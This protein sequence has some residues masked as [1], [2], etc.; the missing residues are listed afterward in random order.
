MT[1]ALSIAASNDAFTQIWV[2]KG[3]YTSIVNIADENAYNTG[4]EE[5]KNKAFLLPAGI[6]I[7]GGFPDTGTPAI[8]D[9]KPY[10]NTTILSGAS[11]YHTIVAIDIAEKTVL[12]GFTISGG[13]ANYDAN[14]ILVKGQTVPK[15]S[16]AGIYAYNAILDL[17]NILL[18]DNSATNNGGALYLGGSTTEVNLVNAFVTKN[19]ATANGGFAYVDTGATLNIYSATITGNTA[20]DG[21]DTGNAIYNNN[22]TVT[23]NSTIIWGNKYADSDVFGTVTSQYSLIK[24]INSGENGN[25]A[26]T[27]NPL[28]KVDN[29]LSL[30][31]S[32]IDGGN[33]N[34]LLP[35]GITKD[36]AGNE[37]IIGDNIDMGA[38][39][40]T[41][42]ET[43][44]AFSHLFV[45]AAVTGGSEDGSSWSNAM[46]SLA[47]ALDFANANYGCITEIWVAQGTYAPETNP[48]SL[49]PDQN[50]AFLL[51]AGVRIYGG[52]ADNLADGE[53]D[54]NDRPF[55][56]QTIL[57][58]DLSS[59]TAYHVLIGVDIPYYETETSTVINTL[60]DGFVITGGYASASSN[61]TVSGYAIN[62]AHGGA[63]CLFNASPVLNNIIVENNK[64]RQH[65]GAFYIDRNS[66]P[67]INNTIFRGNAAS[68]VSAGYGGAMYIFGASEVSMYNVLMHGNTSIQGNNGYGGAICVSEANSV[69]N[70]TNT[71]ITNNRAGSTNLTTSG[72]GI[73]SSGKL[74]VKNSII[75]GNYAGT[76]L[77]T[78][79][80]NNFTNVDAQYS[81]IKGYTSV[82]NGNLPNTMS[83]DFV[84]VSADNYRLSPTSPAIDAGNNS[85]I[86]AGSSTDITG[87]VSRVLNGNV[88]MGAYE[89]DG[90]RE[91][92][93]VLYVNIKAN[94]GGTGASWADPI[95]E[96]S[97]ALE[98]VKPGGEIWVA[99]GT[100]YPQG[101]GYVT[102]NIPDYD[103][104]FAL[105]MGV[106]IY[107]GFPENPTDGIDKIDRTDPDNIIDTRD[108]E[109]N[110]TILSGD[111]DESGSGSTADASHVV[112]GIGLPYNEGNPALNTIL[113]GLVI[114]GGYAASTGSL[115]MQGVNVYRYNGGGMYL[116]NASPVLNNIVF[117]NN[118]A[119]NTS[120]YGGALMLENASSP[121]INN[122][123]FDG[124]IAYNGGGAIYSSGNNA[125]LI[126]N[127]IFKNNRVN[128]SSSTTTTG[129]G[130]GA[131]NI[132]NSG[133]SEITLIN[134]LLH[135]NASTCSGGAIYIYTSSANGS[136]VNLINSTISDNISSSTSPYGGAIYS[137]WGTVNLQNSIVFGNGSVSPDIQGYNGTYN[138]SYS[139][140]RGI[141]DEENGNISGNINPKLTSGYAL[142]ACSPLID[143]GSN[144]LFTNSTNLTTD[145]AG[146]T[147]IWNATDTDDQENATIDIGAY[148]R[149]GSNMSPSKVYVN[150]NTTKLAGT[151]ESWDSPLASLADALDAAECG[152]KEIWVAEGNYYSL[153]EN[154]FILPAGVKIYG[155]FPNPEVAG[156]P[157][158]LDISM[159][160]F[161][162]YP[163]VLDGGESGDIS[164]NSLHTIVGVNITA[165]NETVLD[166]FI[167]RDSQA[168]AYP[169]GTSTIKGVEV[170]KE[171]GGGIYL[172]N[173]SVMLKNII[174]ENCYASLYGGGIY[175][176]GNSN[177]QLVNSLIHGN[178]LGST[179][180]SRGAGIYVDGENTL[181]LVNTTIA[182]NKTSDYTP[183]DYYFLGSGI[184][185]DNG[186]IIIENSIVWGN[187][188]AEGALVHADNSPA[189]NVTR[190]Y[191]MV[192]GIIVPENDPDK[193]IS[194]INPRFVGSYNYRLQP[195]SP[196]LDKGSND[197][198]SA[199]PETD[200]NEDKDLAGNLRFQGTAID[201][202]AFEGGSCG[203]PDID[204][205]ANRRIL[206]HAEG[207]GYGTSWG[208]AYPSLAAAMKKARELNQI[209]E[210]AIT[211]IWV[212]AGTYYP[213]E[214]P[215]GVDTSDDRNKAFVLMEGVSIYGG[216][217]PDLQGSEGDKEDRPFKT[218][219]ILSGDIGYGGDENKIQFK[220]D[221]AAP[222]NDDG[223]YA[224]T[225]DN[226]Y[227]VV[228]S[229]AQ[230]RY[231]IFDG[232]VIEGGTANSLSVSTTGMEAYHG[233]GMYIDN[234]YS[235]LKD[236][237]MRN[238]TANTG[239]GKGGGLYIKGSKELNF[240][241][242]AFINNRA[243]EGGGVYAQGEV[244]VYISNNYGETISSFESN[245]ATIRGGAICSEDNMI[246]ISGN[247]GEN[248]APYGGAI[249]LRNAVINLNEG[250]FISNEA[251]LGGAIYIKELSSY[252]YSYLTA[253][254][255][256]N[257]ATIHGGA[258]YN[259]SGTNQTGFSIFGSSVRFTNNKA[260][261]GNGG[262]VYSTGAL[263]FS[264][265]EY[266]SFVGN[267]ALNGSGGALYLIDN[268][269]LGAT[270]D[271]GVVSGNKAKHSGAGIYAESIDYRISPGFS[272]RDN[273]LENGEGVGAGIFNIASTYNI[274]GNRS[275]TYGKPNFSNII[276]NRSLGEG[277]GIA[278]YLG[279]SGEISWVNISK[280]I[281]GSY[282]AAISNSYSG[283][284]S[285]ENVKI[286][287]NIATGDAVLGRGGAAV[288]N[289]NSEMM[290]IS[291]LVS[292]NQITAHSGAAIFNLSSSPTL[293][294][295]TIVN[296]TAEL[297]GNNDGAA[298]YN[299]GT[300][301]AGSNPL[302]YN[303]IIWGNT[304]SDEYPNVYNDG[305]SNP[306][307]EYSLI[308]GAMPS[309]V[310]NTTFGTDGG[311]NLD[312]DPGFIE[313][314][315]YF[316]L[317]DGGPASGT[318]SINLF[319]NIAPMAA[320]YSSDLFNLQRSTLIDEDT[321]EFAMSRG[322]YEAIECP[323]FINPTAGIV[324]VSEAGSGFM[325][326]SSWTDAYPGLADPL[327]Y[328]A[329]NHGCILEIWVAKGTY[330][331]GYKIAE[332]V[333][334]IN[335]SIPTTSRDK[336]FALVENVKIYGG[337]E[338]VESEKSPQDRDIDKIHT[339][340]QTILSGD[341]DYAESNGNQSFKDDYSVLNADNT[342]KGTEGNAY[343]VVIALGVTKTA[344]LDGFTIEGG[345][346]DYSE[347]KCMQGGY[348]C[349][350]YDTD[351]DYAGIIDVADNN[352]SQY[353]VLRSQG[354]GLYVGQNAIPSLHNLK[355]E[356][357][358]A[359]MYGGGVY[360]EGGIE[361]GLPTRIAKFA[362]P[363]DEIIIGDRS[364]YAILSMDSVWIMNNKAAFGAGVYS[365]QKGLYIKHFDFHNNQTFLID[366]QKDNPVG[367]VGGGIYALQ[368][369][370]DLLN[371][372]IT[373][374][375][376]GRAGGIFIAYGEPTTVT[377]ISP[378]YSDNPGSN[379]E[380]PGYSLTNVTLSS[381]HAVN[382]MT[383][384]ADTDWKNVGGL[385]VD[386]KA[387]HPC[388]PGETGLGVINNSIIWG[389]TQGADFDISN[390]AIGLSRNSATDADEISAIFRNSLMQESNG[391][392]NDWDE[393]RFGTDGLGNIDEDPRFVDYAGRNYRLL[394]TSPA[395]DTGLNKLYT[396][397]GGLITDKDIFDN[398]RFW[399][400]ATDSPIDAVIDMGAFEY[401]EKKSD[402]PLDPDV[403]EPDLYAGKIFVNSLRDGLGESWDCAFHSMY[404]ALIRA[405]QIVAAG[406]AVP[407][408][409][410]AK[411]YYYPEKSR[412][413]DGITY[414]DER[415]KSF[416]L[417]DGVKIYGGYADDLF[418]T[419]TSS[420]RD[421]MAETILSG[422]IDRAENQDNANGGILIGREGNAYHTV[423]SPLVNGALL[424]GFTITGGNAN[425]LGS[426]EYVA[427]IP[428]MNYHG[429]G[430]S[431]TNDVNKSITLTNVTF[432][433]NEADKAVGLGG[434]AYIENNIVFGENV[435]FE[436]NN[437][438][439]GGGLY[440]VNLENIDGTIFTSN[441]ATY[442]G[443]IYA[444]G[445]IFLEDKEDA[446]PTDFSK[447]RASLYG[448]AIYI[449]SKVNTSNLSNF[450]V[451]ENQAA[452]GGGAYVS[453][454]SLLVVDSKFTNN[455]ATVYGGGGLYN[456]GL[457]PASEADFDTNIIEIYS[458]AFSKNK[459]LSGNG[460]AIYTQFGNIA[461]DGLNVENNEALQGS[462]GGIYNLIGEVTYSYYQDQIIT[463]EG[464]KARYEGGGIAIMD[465]PTNTSPIYGSRASFG[466]IRGSIANNSVTNGLGGGIF[467]YNADMVIEPEPENRVTILS[468]SAS[469]EGGGIANYASTTVNVA[470]TNILNNETN[471]Y[472]GG[473]SNSYLDNLSNPDNRSIFKNVEISN[474]LARNI[475]LDE[476]TEN[477][478]GGAGMYNYASSPKLINVLLGRNVLGTNNGAGI[479]NMDESNTTLVNVTIAGN[480]APN[481]EGTGVYINNSNPDIYNTVVAKNSGDGQDFYTNNINGTIDVQHSLLVGLGIQGVG[482]DADGNW[483]D[484]TEPYFRNTVT[485]DFRLDEQEPEQ[486]LINTGNN[487]LYDQYSPQAAAS[488]F[489]LDNKARLD[490]TTIDIGAYE[491]PSPIKIPVTIKVM[492]QGP[493][494]RAVD[495]KMPDN[496]QVG[497]AGFGTVLSIPV[498]NPYGIYGVS[499]PDIHDASKVGNIAD[500][501]HVTIRDVVDPRVI[502]EERA[503]LLRVDGEIVEIDGSVPEF[504]PQDNPVFITVSHRNHMDILSN[505]VVL[506]EN[507]AGSVYDF[508]TDITQ[509]HKHPDFNDLPPMV[510][511]ESIPGVWCMWVGDI[512][513]DGYVDSED[514]GL[515]ITDFRIGVQAEYVDTDVN[516]DGYV[517]S[518]DTGYVRTN[519]RQGPISPLV[520]YRQQLG[521][522]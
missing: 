408:I 513:N 102:V 89:F 313:N 493:M 38:F 23:A 170:N 1:N 463:I 164:F 253:Q 81:L 335:G 17:K 245:E 73:H 228:V 160:D 348:N 74:N 514:V 418:G 26:G 350:W 430:I 8:G 204:V 379:N 137:Y 282:G 471:G 64:S 436:T 422:D 65:G 232:F 381:N 443:G 218:E 22:G 131:I 485:G 37:R 264:I 519:F 165:G 322:A 300:T 290:M 472:G 11:N 265:G 360:S 501:I 261:Q 251:T 63:L 93:A 361:G 255:S 185:N 85:L 42:G 238:N 36:L 451:S 447:N 284:I 324:Y 294:N 363:S 392:G 183:D 492:L 256:D 9:R 179:Y 428:V 383:G 5:L 104:T 118:Q 188:R 405:K 402:C 173:A 35:F 473:V 315:Y 377:R 367:N 479:Y 508:T 20:A 267:E 92:P 230:E 141:E 49:T 77:S 382:E 136:I 446:K 411:G 470:W 502:L 250:T 522:N 71:T 221:Y 96:L 416:V 235:E 112:V 385:Y 495:G 110:R 157:N 130:G 260:L 503:L 424:D 460:G 105:P 215:E 128:R 194:S 67:V 30:C 62:Q 397:A 262:A 336:A 51:P 434:G 461:Y 482:P 466:V 387:I 98:I 286:D 287:S 442:G 79:D 181:H 61:A 120:S 205:Y 139:F 32:A 369:P 53:G 123:V 331:P 500:W 60:L 346:A 272:I 240:S 222:L 271:V 171:H 338:G 462:G 437:A 54:I 155:G 100:Y 72:S 368:A 33:N 87:T 200:I 417:I 211:E 187:D 206:V 344:L 148:E 481:N 341:V 217:A 46:K 371:G 7:L 108:W 506:D 429:G 151:G 143:A 517:D 415:N 145:L 257:K 413:D 515:A 347:P 295:V 285:L 14:P 12:D 234:S 396:D 242:G 497:N 263:S 82:S 276:E 376:A 29:T 117:E 44:P 374:N 414:T 146:A 229:T 339:D 386:N 201:L 184:Y 161:N 504:A 318:A 150:V 410:V 52:F 21:A 132:A 398:P 76:A 86:P 152:V 314:T 465:V 496:L 450:N 483:P 182:G 449:D 47:A 334:T 468:N 18:N 340:N 197:I 337:F 354:G 401:P 41:G 467:N 169:P 227:H 203:D 176:T 40:Y 435:I 464:N 103:K 400:A 498:D 355:I 216:F 365:F 144:E 269:D 147:R 273:R 210:G 90:T 233:G 231:F 316:R 116:N 353:R 247:F 55:K 163:S 484:N 426:F 364:G 476:E 403:I 50:K 135:S 48:T 214:F 172:H 129:Y 445:D 296:N 375:V 241:R 174:V 133:K 380:L 423:V 448:G 268:K 419:D 97:E 19:S 289:G 70:L 308:E 124:N 366:A 404:D 25:I 266:P 246:R 212:A 305:N 292:N 521:G 362:P 511:L 189:E 99:A 444:A 433:E 280:N 326:G 213:D 111:L 159:R 359:F 309:G 299:V 236:L 507:F 474:N 219:T 293:L 237:T 223:T 489:D 388:D 34:A 4:G 275:A 370:L 209:N 456:N 454:S 167:I 452:A 243:A 56:A 252:D 389:N 180:S 281:A 127:T 425:G 125:P 91:Q 320:N 10:Q 193:N 220:D 43:A 352:Y 254:L 427:S 58:G 158:A 277:A 329:D 512:N 351:P 107:G 438:F 192:G 516:F 431:L 394:P 207:S 142:G 140:V 175:I 258:V 45:N 475:M 343:H 478:R 162:L 384:D 126:V 455:N 439:Q 357:N 39:E 510:E 406:G 101:N 407:E 239:V 372:K 80:I 68:V 6:E 198:Y 356:N 69:L 311:N 270:L 321:Y 113:D 488:D 457:V 469:G 319:D 78:A 420:P 505:P 328:A 16:G 28:L 114:S 57:S 325:D 288:F 75:S 499:C 149:Q 226:V 106:K 202:G 301:E 518:H 390:V 349:D 399:N 13:V 306:V 259:N 15:N 199:V 122:T 302:I 491:S 378:F 373:N 291:S 27:T 440:S 168:Y 83:P 166:G 196:L 494:Y 88:D 119:Q 208:C 249:Y 95:K 274:Y 520:R 453:P 330:Y 509:A 459:A 224:N 84:D 94:P 317:K 279:S 186:T 327:K 486:N 332:E 195:S 358:Y 441:N 487:D 115:L 121:R 156:N 342:Y 480:T 421:F 333:Y 278:N 310:W 244:R 138:S 177:V 31:S 323:R 225:D 2:A 345:T 409:Y 312:E 391:S 303:S 191:S 153:T 109:Q 283:L 24:G 3:T 432:T 178:E 395:V 66:K 248:K 307:F 297:T 134:S 154:G 298:I 458:T 59:T 490:D 304:G 477:N 190:K 412:L 393:S